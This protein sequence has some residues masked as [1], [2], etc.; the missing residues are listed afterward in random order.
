MDFKASLEKSLPSWVD[1]DCNK[2]LDWFFDGYVYGTA[3]PALHDHIGVHDPGGDTKVHLV[4]TQS[5]VTDSFRMLVPI[6]IEFADKQVFRLTNLS[7]SGNRTLD[8]VI[9]LGKLPG[10][11]KRLLLNYNYDVLSTEN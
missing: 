8:K 3:V 2:R 10:K 1:S 9:D 5:G 7:L 11:P 6:Y 4:L